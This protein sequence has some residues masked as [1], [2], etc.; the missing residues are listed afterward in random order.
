MQPY[1]LGIDIGTGS[2]KAVAM[3]LTGSVIA[4]VKEHYP[5]QYPQPGFSEQD[6][7]LIW[8]AFVKCVSAI[9]QQL[10]KAPEAI[11]LSSAMHSLIA[12]DDKG[13]ALSPM[14][15]W[16]DTRSAHIAQKM[17]DSADGEHIYRLSG[18]PIHAMSPLCKLIWLQENQT[19]LFNSAHKF[20][21]IKEYIWYQ[22]FGQ[23]EVD[24]SIASTTGLF[25]IKKLV[26]SDELCH[27]A[28]I[29]PHKLSTPVNT[30][31]MRRDIDPAV[32]AQ[33]GIPATTA[34]I[35]G[36]GD[37]CCANLG[38]GVTQPGVAALTIGTSGA[39]RITGV[40][41]VDNYTAM[42]FNYLLNEKTF[43]S[44]GAV[45]N[46]GIAVDWLLKNFMGKTTL[47]A[48]DY[49][50]LFKTIDA[51]PAGSD[52]LL[53]LPYL[54]G[55]RAPIW[56]ANASGA[57][58]NIHAQ[59]TQAYFLRAA[60]EGICYALNDVLTSLEA[61][62][63]PIHQLNVSGGFITSQVWMQLLADITRKKL[64][65]LQLEDAS[66]MGAI[67]L[68]MEAIY[69]KTALPQIAN[70]KVIEPNREKHKH[71]AKTFRIF[72]QLYPDIKNAMHLLKP[73]DQ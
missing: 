57:Y 54:Y 16:A 25:D 61:S 64:A 26:W 50:A 30:N 11:S 23:F 63:A 44:G 29:T 7:D 37:G 20:I 28:G 60:L 41:P 31:Y 10:G 67:Y 56:D 62:S 5:T 33:L 70:S 66:A 17:R 38:S 42:T 46:G 9:S 53:F 13:V 6:T 52:G 49:D 19:E 34:F 1:L 18:T 58:L 24:Y 2:T 32:A 8:H 12:V 73:I 36:A 69:P 21:S 43:I 40:K 72:K 71:Y 27:L 47:T 15:T 35:I 3:A 48:A 65:L 22:L 45:N 59:H 4:T 14:I 51:V 39:V 55:E 68:A